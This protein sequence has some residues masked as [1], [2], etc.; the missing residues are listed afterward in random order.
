MQHCFLLFA[1]VLLKTTECGLGRDA[2]FFPWIH[3]DG[4]GTS[5]S[6][7]VRARPKFCPRSRVCML[8]GSKPR[9]NGLY[10]CS[11]P[12][13]AMLGRGHTNAYFEVGTFGQSVVGA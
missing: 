2:G 5:F 3:I 8:H 7:R 9:G 13:P 10:Y 4:A 11:M 6:Q 12:F 1:G